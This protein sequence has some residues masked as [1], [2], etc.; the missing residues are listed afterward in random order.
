LGGCSSSWR[1]AF[2]P[3]PRIEVVRDAIP[4]DF[5][6]CEA[7]PAPLAEQP[8]PSM[9]EFGIWVEAVRAAGEDCRAKLGAVARRQAEPKK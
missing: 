5:L 2:L 1:P 7:E 9:L 8:W 3:A 4:A 6:A